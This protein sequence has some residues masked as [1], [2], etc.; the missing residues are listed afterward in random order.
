ME[1]KKWNLTI[2]GIIV[3]CVAILVVVYIM[4]S[5]TVINGWCHATVSL[6]DPVSLGENVWMVEIENVDT[7]EGCSGLEFFGVFLEQGES[8]IILT[9]P[10][11]NGLTA[12]ADAILI[13]FADQGT[14]GSVGSGDQFYLVNLEVGYLYK[15]HVL[16]GWGPAGN[17]TVLT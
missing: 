5:G 9:Y 15:F 6:H 11:Q 17:V 3:I 13:F 14:V 8:T 10:L 1:R 16:D 4:L 7:T 12:Q 2:A